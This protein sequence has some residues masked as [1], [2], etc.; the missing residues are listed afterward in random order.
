M[1]T[2]PSTPRLIK[3]GYPTSDGKPMA[4]TDTH[5]DVMLELIET[6]KDLYRDNPRVYVSGNLLVFYEPGNKRKHVSPDVFLVKG[7]GNQN[8]PN[9][10]LWEERNLDF[11]IEVSSMTTRMEDLEDKYELYQDKLKAREYFLF[12]PKAEYLNPPLQGHRLRKGVYRPIRPVEGRLPSQVLGLHL[13]RHGSQLRFYDP[14]TK[15]W[16]PNL[17]ERLA[18]AARAQ[19]AESEVERLR[20]EIEELR[21]QLPKKT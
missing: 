2:V 21:R 13:E 7:V 8:R 11:V 3:N 5:R 20:R 4:E 19:Q 17:Q 18:L 1:A 12:D 14:A 16:L 6:L 9:Y 10:L 15:Q